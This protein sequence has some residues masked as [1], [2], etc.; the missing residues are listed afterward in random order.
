MEDFCVPQSHLCDNNNNNDLD[1]QTFDSELY[2]SE[3]RA[4]GT[5]TDPGDGD[6][7]EESKW[8]KPCVV[9]RYI[10]YKHDR[11]EHP[12]VQ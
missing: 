6:G 3:P 10:V 1:E 8:C 2:H 4:E 7:D 11:N 9:L 5:H 12:K